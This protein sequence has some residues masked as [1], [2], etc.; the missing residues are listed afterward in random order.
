VRKST[1]KA[2]TAAT[3]APGTACFRSVPFAVLVALLLPLLASPGKAEN[4]RPTP[5]PLP[6]GER[7]AANGGGG[8]GEFF[9]PPIITLPSQVPVTTTGST[10]EACNFY[11]GSCV[12]FPNNGYNAP[13][14]LYYYTAP[15]P[16]TYIIDTAGSAYDTLLYVF[17]SDCGSIDGA[18]EGA[19]GGAG[20]GTSCELA[21]D[22]DSGPGLTSRVSLPLGGGQQILIMVDGYA[23]SQGSYVLNINTPTPTPTITRT[24]TRTRTPTVTR[25]R[26][27]TPT[28]TRTPTLQPTP[29]PCGNGIVEPELEE[30]CDP[31]F[32]LPNDCCT[33]TCQFQPAGTSCNDALFCTA[34]DQCNANGICIGSGDPCL[35]LNTTDKNCRG[36]CN[37]AMNNCSAID[38][39]GTGC[40][41]FTFC[42][43]TDQCGEDG[44]C[45]VHSGN[46]CPPHDPESDDCTTL[47][48]EFRD[49]CEGPRHLVGCDDGKFCNGADRCN[50]GECVPIGINPCPGPDGD[51]DCSESCDEE[52]RSCT[53]NDPDGSLCND[54]NPATQ[55]DVC[56]DGQCVGIQLTST[57]TPTLTFTSKPTD[58]RTPSHTP[59]VTNTRT[60]T[61]TPTLPRTFTPTR[62]RTGTR[63]PTPIRTSTDTPSRT[64]TATH[65]D[66]PSQTPSAT[67]T[68]TGT[69]QP[70]PTPTATPVPSDTPAP[71]PTET[72]SRT[73]TI[74]ATRTR[75]NTA[76]PGPSD[77]PTRTETNTPPPPSPTASGTPT[78]TA[79]RRAGFNTSRRSRP[80]VVPGP[81]AAGRF[82]ADTSGAAPFDLVVGSDTEPRLALLQGENLETGGQGNFVS[83]DEIQVA[84]GSGGIGDVVV[85][86]LDGDDMADIV[87]TVPGSNQ[88][89]VA[90]TATPHRFGSP[91][92]ISVAG[93]PRA[94]AVGDVSNDGNAD[95]LVATDTGVRVLRG[96][97]NGGFA[98]LAEVPTGAR[99]VSLG[100][101]HV[102]GTSALDLFVVLTE[103]NVVRVL[104]GQG[105]GTFI[106][107]DLDRN[108]I[109]PLAFALG[110]LTGDTRLD[111]VVAHAAGLSIFPGTPSGFGP[112]IETGEITASQLI[113]ADLNG[114][115]HSDVIVTDTPSNSVRALLGD[116]A[117]GL[118]D[119]P[120]VS[121][122]VNADAPI[123]DVLAADLVSDRRVDLAV[124]VPLAGVLIIAE[125]QEQGLA[126]SFCCAGDCNRNCRVT[127]NEL[128][129][130]VAIMFGDAPLEACPDFNADGNDRLTVDELLIGVENGLGG[131]G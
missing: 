109:R 50:M 112:P 7:E 39:P 122:T 52:T 84:G 4:Q 42:N 75:T 116:G 30:Q 70:T 81:I 110:E 19:D 98:P 5:T 14:R 71:T 106:P 115:Q 95:V 49:N 6:A 62:T 85:A 67:F 16:G 61:N 97:G 43:G 44:E 111:M 83:A 59:T 74:T 69:Q 102:S 87:A 56:Q 15:A 99:P 108:V 68:F 91:Q 18:G 73:P 54:G 117:G 53:V 65:T 126:P 8:A 35:P 58:T 94:L 11:S 124:S 118:I 127:I 27:P 105:D 92:V 2:L 64:P 93:A 86:P 79:T 21:C 113:V 104:L 38:P 120:E 80:P 101:A 72:S 88:V 96:D 17:D 78:A 51:A 45:S 48:D 31:G 29:N 36:S 125:N 103:Q 90:L 46:P 55:L 23:S 3:S 33:S 41:D 57:P 100:L 107:S 40:D 128:V 130:G 22:D 82:A 123:A 10:V 12:F 1:S 76:R 63:T 121:W 25:T 24:P 114:D 60:V 89:V 20:A 131:C 13:E 119:D 34:V 129:L 9:C 47:C 28:R 77:T 26:T 66:T 32:D 37:E